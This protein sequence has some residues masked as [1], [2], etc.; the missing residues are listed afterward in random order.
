[1]K[2]IKDR[3]KVFHGPSIIHKDAHFAHKTALKLDEKYES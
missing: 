2:N 1:L 3:E